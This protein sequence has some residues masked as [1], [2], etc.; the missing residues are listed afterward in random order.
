[1]GRGTEGRA[2]LPGCVIAFCV[3]VEFKWIQYCI[4]TLKCAQKQ[5]FHL[6]FLNDEIRITYTPRVQS[7]DS[8]SAQFRIPYIKLVRCKGQEVPDKVKY[9]QPGRLVKGFNEFSSASYQYHQYQR[10]HLH[11]CPLSV[12][13][14]RLSLNGNSPRILYALCPAKDSLSH[15]SIAVK[16]IKMLAIFKLQIIWLNSSMRNRC[17]DNLQIGL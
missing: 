7:I 10:Y 15:F 4:F 6:H 17:E 16:L 13:F 14:N 12:S 2:G 8:A 9:L 3:T 1:M 5:I 11:L